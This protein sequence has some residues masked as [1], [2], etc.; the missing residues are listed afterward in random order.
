MSWEGMQKNIIIKP[1]GKGSFVS[2][3]TVSSFLENICTTGIHIKDELNLARHFD[4]P[5]LICVDEKHLDF[6]KGPGSLKVAA[7]ISKWFNSWKQ[8]F[9]HWQD[10]HYML[11][12]SKKTLQPCRFCSPC[13]NSVKNAGAS[14]PPERETPL[15][16]ERTLPYLLDNAYSW[17]LS[18]KISYPYDILF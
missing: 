4:R 8:S 1:C 5:E 14:P 2:E 3:D 13:P 10:L 9:R 6:L 12:L 16:T 7:A 11:I 18:P 15:P 17:I